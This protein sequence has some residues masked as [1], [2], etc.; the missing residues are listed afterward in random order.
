MLAQTFPIIVA[1]PESPCLLGLIHAVRA[2]QVILECP[3]HLD[4][5]LQMAGVENDPLFPV[6]LVVVL[7]EPDGGIESFVGPIVSLCEYR[8]VWCIVTVPNLTPV[9]PEALHLFALFRIVDRS[10]GK[11]DVFFLP[12]QLVEVDVPYLASLVVGEVRIVDHDMDT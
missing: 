9:P 4:H 11:L 1:S 2:A 5:L 3:R 6:A 8:R 7:G 12:L 10:L